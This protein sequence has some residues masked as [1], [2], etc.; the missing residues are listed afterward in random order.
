MAL[1]LTISNKASHQ[2]ILAALAKGDPSRGLE[3][4]P[5]IRAAVQELSSEGS[6]SDG[7]FLIGPEGK[8]DVT[9]KV[10][11]QGAELSRCDLQ[12]TA[13][14]VWTVPADETAPY[15]SPPSIEAHWEVEAAAI[16][17][18]KVNLQS[19]TLRLHKL[20]A[21]TPITDELLDDSSIVAYLNRKAPDAIRWRAF[22]AI[23]WG[24]G[25]GQPLGFMNSPALVTVAIEAGPQTADTFVKA[26]ATKMASR[27]LHTSWP[28][29]VWFAHPDSLEQIYNNCADIISFA[30]NDVD[31][32]AGRM[33]GRPIIPHEACAPLG[34]LGDVV[35]ADLSQYLAVTKIYGVKEQISTHMWFDRD[36]SAFKF[37][38]RLAGQPWLSA[39]VPSRV[40]DGT[41]SPFVCLGAR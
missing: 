6:G 14:N 30:A 2:F 7:G 13:R 3:N 16:R 18:S 20:T 32:P 23:M 37:T 35:L 17:Q 15:S 31:A 1:R 39:P 11:A 25:V 40:G 5:E 28:T 29:A 24:N 21:L 19:R 9:A 26:N 4:R 33:L 34:D 10:V 27:L 38:F 8:L 41:R 12:T 22:F 36:L